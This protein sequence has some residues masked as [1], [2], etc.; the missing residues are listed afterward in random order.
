M[1][2]RQ[3]TILALLSIAIILHSCNFSKSVNTDLLTGL[4]TVG[5]GLSCDDVYMSMADGQIQKNTFIFGEEFDG[6]YSRVC[7]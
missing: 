1:K 3:L 7:H 4:T 6:L 5:N 2:N